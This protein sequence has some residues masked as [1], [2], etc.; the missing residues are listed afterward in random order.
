MGNFFGLD[1]AEQH[2]IAKQVGEKIAPALGGTSRWDGGDEEAIVTGEFAG[3][4]VRIRL[5]ATF[6]TI[7]FELKVEPEFPRLGQFHLSQD[8]DGKQNQPPAPP[9]DDF[10]DPTRRDDFTYYVTNTVNAGNCAPDAAFTIDLLER[11]P[12]QLKADL[13]ARLEPDHSHINVYW[14]EIQLRCGGEPLGDDDVEE[15]VQSYLSLA[16]RLCVAFQA[17]WRVG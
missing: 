9:T 10:E 16:A 5:D 2:R 6:G 17:I 12:S 14:K 3:F 7:W 11:L 13:L 4:P 8:S 15:V 1:D